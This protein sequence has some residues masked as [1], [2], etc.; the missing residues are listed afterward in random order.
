M[1]GR[2]VMRNTEE[3][4]LVKLIACDQVE[5]DFGVKIDRTGAPPLAVFRQGDEFFVIDDT[6]SHGDASLSDG[7]LC[8]NR[9]LKNS[10]S[11][12]P[13]RSG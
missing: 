13:T 11:T 3:Q 1:M 10:A 5:E 6:C 2:S 7:E 4:Q 8:P 9:P 12:A